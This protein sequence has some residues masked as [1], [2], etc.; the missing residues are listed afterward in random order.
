[1]TSRFQRERN[2][3][4]L[5][6]LLRAL[7]TPKLRGRVRAEQQPLYKR[8]DSRL[9][10]F[11]VSFSNTIA[12]IT[13][14]RLQRNVPNCSPI[15]GAMVSFLQKGHRGIEKEKSRQDINLTQQPASLSSRCARCRST[16]STRTGTC[17]PS[18]RQTRPSSSLLPS[19][20]S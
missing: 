7:C 3:R 12:L 15:K 6:R 8:F 19:A 14:Q 9:R 18:P 20:P 4:A 10:F 16:L 13:P 2:S 11:S 17:L 1:V 5:Y